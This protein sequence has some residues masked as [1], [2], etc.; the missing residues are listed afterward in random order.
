MIQ[1]SKQLITPQKNSTSD[2]FNIPSIRER[3]NFRKKRK[4]AITKIKDP[5]A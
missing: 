5:A 1:R 3:L 2:R 4:G